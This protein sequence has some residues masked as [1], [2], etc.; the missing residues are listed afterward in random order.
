ML[1]ENRYFCLRVFTLL[2]LSINACIYGAETSQPSAVTLSVAHKFLKRE[3][4]PNPKAF[5]IVSQNN[6]QEIIG[7][8]TIEK[9]CAIF[10]YDR[11][12]SGYKEPPR[13]RHA[14]EQET[15]LGMHP[16]VRLVNCAYRLPFSNLD[17]YVQHFPRLQYADFLENH[18]YV[19]A[20]WQPA[21]MTLNDPRVLSFDAPFLYAENS[22]KWQNLLLPW[23]VCVKPRT[24]DLRDSDLSAWLLDVKQQGLGQ[25]VRLVVSPTDGQKVVHQKMGSHCP[26]WRVIVDTCYKHRYTLAA[27]G[28]LG[29]TLWN[30][31]SWHPELMAQR[32][33]AIV[34][35]QDAITKQEAHI[36]HLQSIIDYARDAAEGN[37]TKEQI[38][39]ACTTIDAA[40]NQLISLT[41]EPLTAPLGQAGI[42]EFLAVFLYKRCRMLGI[43]LDAACTSSTS[44]LKAWAMAWYMHVCCNFAGYRPYVHSEL[45]RYDSEH[46]IACEDIPSNKLCACYNLLDGGGI[47]YCKDIVMHPDDAAPMVA[48]NRKIAA[49]LVG[50]PVLGVAGYYA[51]QKLPGIN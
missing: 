22:L 4:V 30:L 19:H 51:Y 5:S 23:A 8:L 38:Y 29:A 17:T 33:S 13:L 26:T 16:D 50:A 39:H 37:F 7:T 9:A 1:K 45:V 31:K 3:N 44:M 28:V 49:L 24:F 10:F 40:K 25:G 34:C 46:L 12:T 36:A 14:T 35:W 21:P 48:R 47:R 6:D 18:P 20:S 11:P 42:F 32:E 15:E 43:A 41:C 2:L 27:A